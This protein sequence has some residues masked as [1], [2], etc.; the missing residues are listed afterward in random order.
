MQPWVPET[1]ISQIQTKWDELEDT[2]HS[3]ELALHEQLKRQERLNA[4]AE[5]FRTKAQ[6]REDWL[7]AEFKKVKFQSYFLENFLNLIL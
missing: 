7:K 2:E 6:L 1:P 5:N 3:R 4:L